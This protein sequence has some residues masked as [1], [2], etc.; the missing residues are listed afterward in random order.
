MLGTNDI[1]SN[2]RILNNENFVNQYEKDI[3]TVEEARINVNKLGNYMYG[4]LA[5][6]LLKQKKNKKK[7]DMSKI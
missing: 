3:N 6:K 4:K 1:F 2:I 7:L 5:L